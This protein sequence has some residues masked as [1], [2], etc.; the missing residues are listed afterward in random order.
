MQGRID[1]RRKVANVRAI[2]RNLGNEQQQRQRQ[3]R[4]AND[5]VPAVVRP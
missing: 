5:I 3:E 4:D 2:K 1:P